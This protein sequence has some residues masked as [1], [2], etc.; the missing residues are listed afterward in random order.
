MNIDHKKLAEFRKNVAGINQVVPTI[1]KK[2]VRYVHFDNAASTPALLPVLQEMEEFMGWYSGVHRGTGYKSLVS[3]RVYDDCH[4]I[5][6]RYLK[7]DMDKNVVILLKNTTEAI[8]KL[9]YRLQLSAND[10]VISTMMEHHSNDLPWRKKAVLKYAEVDGQGILDVNDIEKKLKHHYPRVKLLTVTGASNVTGHTNDIHRLA[11]LAHAYRAQIMVDGA[12]LIPHQ[13]VDIKADHDPRHIDYIAFSGHKL[14]APF[15]TG[16]LIGPRNTFLTGEPE[17][18][19]GGTVDMVTREHAFWANLPDREEAG[20]PNLVGAFTL[21]KTMQYLEKIGMD[22]LACHESQLVDYALRELKQVP[23]LI[24]YGSSPRVG[25]ISFNMKGFSHAQLGAILCFEAGI[26]VRTGCFCAQGYV[27]RLL[28][29]KEDLNNLAAYEN[30]EMDRLPGMVRISLAAYNTHAEI[31][32]LVDWLKKIAKNKKHYQKNYV[33]SPDQC[34]Y[35]PF[36][37]DSSFTKSMFYK[38]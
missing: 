29:E 25:V 33:F 15:G 37:V 30:K 11:E 12:Q 17:Y 10:I 3:S 14:Y 38:M 36:G 1:H 4:Q 7:T 2:K 9:S 22:H 34:S 27:R 31:D 20:S 8:N 35:L 19:G 18:V 24:I 28:G 26:G 16:V 13:Q 5:I 6:G 23:G 21:A 32:N